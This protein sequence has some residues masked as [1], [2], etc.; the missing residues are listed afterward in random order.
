MS[1]GLLFL[2]SLPAVKL[3]DITSVATTTL[4]GSILSGSGLIL[5]SFVT[6][7]YALYFVYSVLFGVGTSFLY[8]PCL[9]IVGKWFQKY[10]AATTGAA[11]A[12]AAFGS[13]V[14]SPL[15]QYVL[16]VCGLRQ[17]VR[18]CGIIYLGMVIVCSLCY[19]PL[20]YQQKN[21]Y[22][23]GTEIG[24]D[25]TEGRLITTKENIVYA[26]SHHNSTKTVS[27]FKNKCFVLYLVALIITNFCYYIPLI[28]LVRVVYGFS[29]FYTNFNALGIIQWCIQ[30]YCKIL[31]GDHE[32]NIM[33]QSNVNLLLMLSSMYFAVVLNTP[34]VCVELTT[35]HQTDS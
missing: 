2:F 13:V 4:I 10:Q 1:S 9:I 29:F 32:Q 15:T 5:T 25:L 19:K 21:M 8:A 27:I 35:T 26:S 11:C 24:E 6:E 23:Q 17:T 30:R 28:H 3:C 16:K 31:G 18:W 34:M 20:Q 14:L 7:F 22:S 33:T 12:S